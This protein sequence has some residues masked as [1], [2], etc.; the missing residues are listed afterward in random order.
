[1]VHTGSEKPL[2]RA[3][4]CNPLVGALTTGAS[5]VQ[6]VHLRWRLLHR[7]AVLR[8]TRRTQGACITSEA[9]GA[10]N[11]TCA[12]LKTRDILSSNGVQLLP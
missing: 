8:A 1:M 3:Y 4:V 12:A 5:L 2:N 10:C 11:T 6:F 9:A 7:Y